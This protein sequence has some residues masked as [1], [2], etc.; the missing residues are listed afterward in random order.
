MAPQRPRKS[1]PTEL[2]TDDEDMI[3]YDMQVEEL[4]PNP[5]DKFGMKECFVNNPS[6]YMRALTLWVGQNTG[7][8]VSH[9]TSYP[10]PAVL[11]PPSLIIFQDVKPLKGGKDFRKVRLNRF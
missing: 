7:F 9:K 8:P 10:C 2:A 5:E 6:K 3:M 4:E 1:A 11:L